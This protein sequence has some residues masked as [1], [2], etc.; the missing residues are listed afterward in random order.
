VSDVP[1]SE[2]PPGAYD[3]EEI[4][5]N[6][7]LVVFINGDS[8]LSD[9]VARTLEIHGYHVVT[10]DHRVGECRLASPVAHTRGR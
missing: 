10:A 2:A 4:T 5:N 7:G 3:R 9:R 8:R 6:K 1:N